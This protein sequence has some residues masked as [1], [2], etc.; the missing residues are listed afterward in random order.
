MKWLLTAT[1]LLLLSC[2]Q[3]RNGYN[4]FL[5]NSDRVD[6]VVFN[7]G[8]TLFYDT[9]DSTGLRILKNVITGNPNV[10]KDTCVAQG[11]LR[12]RQG[13]TLL[14]QARF[15]AGNDSCNHVS[16]AD[17]DNSY[18]HPLSD[19]ANKLLNKILKTAGKQ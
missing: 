5:A 14:F 16:Y 13:E 1:L 17:D 2:K 7:G 18:I 12:Y 9:K 6:I 15:A 10:L 8:D 19:R 11:Y 3:Q 4:Q